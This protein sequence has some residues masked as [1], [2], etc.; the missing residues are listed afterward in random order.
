MQKGTQSQRKIQK[1]FK[2]PSHK[3]CSVFTQFTASHPHYL[4]S[5]NITPI[6]ETLLNAFCKC[7]HFFKAPVVAT[8]FEQPFALFP[9]V[10]QLSVNPGSIIAEIICST[11]GIKFSPMINFGFEGK[12]NKALLQSVFFLLLI[13]TGNERKQ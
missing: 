8:S 2:K 11:C 1:D 3:F 9:D 13:S 6:K 10:D 12:S 4:Y 5:T 7:Q